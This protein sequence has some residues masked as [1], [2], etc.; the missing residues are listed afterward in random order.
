MAQGIALYSQVAAT[1]L[2]AGTLVVYMRQAGLM[3]GSLESSHLQI[4]DLQETRSRQQLYQV[5]ILLTDMIDDL[6]RVL[7]LRN[8]PHANWT[9]EEKSSAFKVCTRFNIVGI[10]VAENMIRVD[11]LAE[12]WYYSIPTT[13]KI[14]MPYLKVIRDERSPYYWS[15][16]DYLADAVSKHTTDFRGFPHQ[17]AVG[18]DGRAAG[19]GFWHA[20]AHHLAAFPRCGDRCR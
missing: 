17:T 4:A 2:I 6:E 14:L 19:A 7:S 18:R 15:A 3:K 8:K 11:L 9:A 13:H 12:G 5:F 20:A 10:L 1:L 16:Y